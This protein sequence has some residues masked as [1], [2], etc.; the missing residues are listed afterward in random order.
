MT[1]NSDIKI[2]SYPNFIDSENNIINGV[3]LFLKDKYC[4]KFGAEISLKKN[5]PVAAGLA[6]GS[7]DAAS[8]IVGLNKLWNLNMSFEEMNQTAKKFGSDIN[9]FLRGGSAI[10]TGRGEK[11]FSIEDIEIENIVLIKPDFGIAAQKAY[12]IVSSRKKTDE[13]WDFFSETKNVKFCYNDLEENIIKEY[14]VL[15]KI[16]SD[17]KMLGGQPMLSGS[18]S[19]VISFC[20]DLLSAKNIKDHFTNKNYWTYIT[21]TIRRQK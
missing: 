8:T 3:S 21:K 5:I 2:W 16:F 15:W 17:V 19:T 11:V 14:P 12:Q 1:K 13:K 10:G 9:F 20:G 4:V 18:G 6:G 7:S